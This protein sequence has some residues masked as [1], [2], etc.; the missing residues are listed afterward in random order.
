MNA[1]PPPR[2]TRALVLLGHGSSTDH[3]A[4]EGVR[5]QA[6]AIRRLGLFDKVLAA[7]WKEKPH[8]REVLALVKSDDLLLVPCFLSQGYFTRQVIPRAFGLTGCVTRLG[9]RRL[10]Y[11]EPLGEHPAITLGRLGG[12][13]DA[14]L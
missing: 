2:R 5:F 3:Q 13:R 7:F 4:G 14:L 8:F 9:G 10:W 1:V 6:R 12:A 11:G